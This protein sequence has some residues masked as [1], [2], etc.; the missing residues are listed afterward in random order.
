MLVV[1]GTIALVVYDRY[2]LGFLRRAW[3]NMDLIW[4]VTLVTAGIVTLLT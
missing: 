3:F 1:M 2:G 4:A